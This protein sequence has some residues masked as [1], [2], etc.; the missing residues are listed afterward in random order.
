[1][2][3]AKRVFVTGGYHP[4]VIKTGRKWIS[5]V[6]RVDSFPGVRVTKVRIKNN[7]N[8]VKDIFPYKGKP[9]P[10][11]RVIQLLNES[12]KKY[13]ITKGARLLLQEADHGI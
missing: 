9:Y 12:G 6:H 8:E 11:E 4:C 7:R 1:M 5:C 2:I 3:A 10:I 13:G